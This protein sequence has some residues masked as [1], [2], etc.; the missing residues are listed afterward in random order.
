MRNEPLT[1][2]PLL[3]L[4]I[5]QGVSGAPK[6]PAIGDLGGRA[7]CIVEPEREPIG[8]K[9]SRQ[10]KRING[11]S[12]RRWEPASRPRARTWHEQAPDANTKKYI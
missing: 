6:Q 11:R 10:R 4:G 8:R 1:V 5:P 2:H 7:I 12:F 9:H 3:S